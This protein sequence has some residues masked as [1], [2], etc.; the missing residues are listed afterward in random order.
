MPTSKLC[1]LCVFVLESILNITAHFLITEHC[2]RDL[3]A[4]LPMLTIENDKQELVVAT[5]YIL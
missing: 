1:C 5:A 3:V 2:K 4:T